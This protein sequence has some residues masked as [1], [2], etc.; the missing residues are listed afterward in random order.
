ER[1]LE[2]EGLNVEYVRFG[3]L[4]EVNR[5]LMSGSIDIA[6][7]GGT[8]PT[9]LL[10]VEGVPATVVLANLIA[11]ANFVVAADSDITSLEQ[12]RGKKIGSTPAGSTAHALVGAILERG[13]KISRDQYEHIGAGEGQLVTLLQTGELDA[14]L[15]RTI[16]IAS[17]EAKVKVLA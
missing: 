9:L 5:A 10:G 2:K 16:T 11:D 17:V 13:Y 15:L 6:V 1:F 14:A 8:I 12:L 3:R 4:G 7:A